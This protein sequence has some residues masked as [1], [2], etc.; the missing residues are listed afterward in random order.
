[1]IEL[2]IRLVD[3]RHFL[4]I[5]SFHNGFIISQEAFK[6]ASDQLALTPCTLTFQCKRVIYVV[7]MITSV[8]DIYRIFE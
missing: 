7:A 4:T 2:S 1:M 3:Y 8:I 5:S 6:V